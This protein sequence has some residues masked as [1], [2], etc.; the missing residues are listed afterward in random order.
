MAGKTDALTEKRKR[1]AGIAALSVVLLSPV[2]ITFIST[3]V[4]LFDSEFYDREF[5]KYDFI[6]ELQGVDLSAIHNDIMSFFL[7][8][9]D[10]KESGIFDQKEISHLFDVRKI[11]WIG[12]AFFILAIGICIFAVMEYIRNSSLSVNSWRK[13]GIIMTAGGVF[14]LLL[15]LLLWIVVTIDFGGVFTVFHKLLFKD[16]TWLFSPQEKIVLIYQ[17]GLFNHAAFRLAYTII[18]IAI[19]WIASS[20][21]VIASQREKKI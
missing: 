8:R 3:N 21:G 18:G 2:L 1:K 4:L 15:A 14:T 19:V 11:I 10:I 13:G 9:A 6:P 7:F 17:E 20:L 12:E 16:G 5:L